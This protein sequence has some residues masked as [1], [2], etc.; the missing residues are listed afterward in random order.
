M[1]CRRLPR[2]ATDDSQELLDFAEIVRPSTDRLAADVIEGLPEAERP[3]G[4]VRQHLFR[5]SKA[6]CVDASD[7]DEESLSLFR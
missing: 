2:S 6:S 7:A 5:E 1:P 3:S 4:T